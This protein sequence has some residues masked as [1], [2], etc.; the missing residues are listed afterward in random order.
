MKYTIYITA[1]AVKGLPKQQQKQTTKR[2]GN[3][4]SGYY[5]DDVK[6]FEYFLNN[7]DVKFINENRNGKKID[8]PNKYY[9]NQ[10]HKRNNAIFY[11]LDNSIVKD[12]KNA[13]NTAFALSQSLYSILTMLGK[14]ETVY[15][16]NSVKHLQQFKGM[17]YKE[18]DR[19]LHIVVNLQVRVKGVPAMH[20]LNS[21]KFNFVKKRMHRSTYRK[22]IDLIQLVDKQAQFLQVVK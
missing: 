3:R 11:R 4:L 15:N 10:R 12:V 7:D 22:L 14:Q 18:I 21:I 2:K 5:S 1:K 16:G 20:E 6:D 9:N 19:Y 8:R 17:K 13:N